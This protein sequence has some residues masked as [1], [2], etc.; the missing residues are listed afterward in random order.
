[1]EA[2]WMW[3]DNV[4][5]ERR[6]EKRKK[7][8]IMFLIKIGR[9]F[10]G[11]GIVKDINQ[12]SMRLMCPQLFKPRTTIQSNGYIGE[13]LRV[14]IPSDGITINGVIARVDLKK[15]EGAI[16]ISSTSDNSRWQKLCE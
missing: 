14:M 15:G 8:K 16:R 13:S 9:L 1:V 7:V 12:H 11:R 4:I 6:I 5:H 10:S 2:F 3:V